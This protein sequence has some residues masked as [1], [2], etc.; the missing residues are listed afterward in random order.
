MEEETR[1]EET[2][3]KPV[4]EENVTEEP[5]TEESTVVEEKNTTEYQLTQMDTGFYGGIAWATVSSDAGTKHVL[6]NKD[7]LKEY[8]QELL[9]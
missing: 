9:D 1:V 7:L 6:I 5:T 4:T 3:E 2:V 8:F